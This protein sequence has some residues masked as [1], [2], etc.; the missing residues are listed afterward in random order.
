MQPKRF[1]HRDRLKVGG[2]STVFLAAPILSD[3]DYEKQLP[4]MWGKHEWSDALDT[5]CNQPATAPLAY[6]VRAYKLAD[7]DKI[8][9]AMERLSDLAE[10]L[11]R[12]SRDAA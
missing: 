10:A 4:L 2:L 3:E 7:L 6:A 9:G 8:L 5:I 12:Y 11:Q 1:Y